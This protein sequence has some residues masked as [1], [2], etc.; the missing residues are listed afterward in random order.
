MHFHAGKAGDVL[1]RSEQLRIAEQRRYEATAGMLPVEQF[2]RDH[3]RQTEAVS[4]VVMRFLSKARTA[5]RRAACSTVVFGHKV[6]EGFRAGPT[7]IAARP[8]GRRRLSRDLGAVMQLVDLANLYDKRIEPDTWDIVRRHAAQLPDELSRK[9]MKHFFSL[10]SH[11]ARLGDLL[12]LLHEVGIL[13]RFIPAYSHARG[14]LQFNQY[15]KYT[16]DEHCFRAIDL[17]TDLQWHQGMLGQAY[18]EIGRKHVLHL[19]LLLHDLGKGYAD[20]HCEVGRRLAV[21]NAR[22]LGLSPEDSETLEFLVAN[23]QVMNYLAFRRDTTD[24]TALDTVRG[25]RRFPP[26][27]YECCS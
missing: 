11:P 2:M 21:E 22:L 18:R 7:L 1:S 16:V 3:F 25:G 12:R 4:H 20:D 27:D 17:A 24:G 19:A 8:R 6:A 13:E 14:L 5:S 23:H 10:V 26:S 9:A 15:H